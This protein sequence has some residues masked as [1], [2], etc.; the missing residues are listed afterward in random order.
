[1]SVCP[2]CQRL[3]ETWNGYPTRETSGEEAC[4][5]HRPRP[6]GDFYCPSCDQWMRPATIRSNVRRIRR[7]PVTVRTANCPTCEFPLFGAEMAEVFYRHELQLCPDRAGGPYFVPRLGWGLGRA[8]YGEGHHLQIA[9]QVLFSILCHQGDL[10]RQANVRIQ[11]DTTVVTHVTEVWS[12][13]ARHRARELMT[14]FGMPGCIW[15]R[16]RLGPESTNPGLLIWKCEGLVEANAKGSELTGLFLD[17]SLEAG[18]NIQWEFREKEGLA[19]IPGKLVYKEHW[20]G[21]SFPYDVEIGWGSKMA[22]ASH[23]VELLSGTAPLVTLDPQHLRLK[24]RA[25]ESWRAH[26]KLELESA[27]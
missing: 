4:E 8:E 20:G 13:R 23:H 1:M 11:S 22:L 10:R 9:S 12:D 17:S 26:V 3:K 21:Q 15:R 25:G 6:E 27:G 14:R 5:W 19:K 24:A 16:F 18:E 7:T 2:H